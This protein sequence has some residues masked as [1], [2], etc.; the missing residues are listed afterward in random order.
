MNL[1]SKRRPS[2]TEFEKNTGQLAL[3]LHVVDDGVA[4]DFEGW[5]L[6]SLTLRCCEL[7]RWENNC[8]M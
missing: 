1:L 5:R 7:V 8:G 6:L 3:E 4:V 2:N